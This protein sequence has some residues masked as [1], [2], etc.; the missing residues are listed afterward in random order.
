M[1]K[2]Y[3]PEYFKGRAAMPET[4]NEVWTIFEEQLMAGTTAGANIIL[5]DGQPRMTKQVEIIRTKYGHCRHAYL[6][7]MASR[8]ACEERARGRDASPDALALSMK[9]MDNDRI[10]LFDVL[11]LIHLHEP[12][13]LVTVSTQGPFDPIAVLDLC[14][15]A[16][17]LAVFCEPYHPPHA[18]A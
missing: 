14:T 10:Q 2:R 13:A 7:L 6:H 16:A 11:T 15:T 8:E 5:I 3:P 17:S 18:N 4:E 1:R 9:R 12:R